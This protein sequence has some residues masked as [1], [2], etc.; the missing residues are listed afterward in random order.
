L[1]AE[2]PLAR[3][4]RSG[5]RPVAD[6]RHDRFAGGL[7]VTFHGARRTTHRR[8]HLP[9]VAAKIPDQPEHLLLFSG[10][11]L[12]G[13]VECLPAIQVV[14]PLTSGD[15]VGVLPLITAAQRIGIMMEGM[16]PGAGIPAGEVDE[17]VVH[18]R[19]GERQQ[20][21]RRR[22]PD[23]R[24]RL[25]QPHQDTLE[26]VAG[27]VPSPHLGKPQQHS[28]G[29]DTE[30]LDAHLQQLVSGPQ[31]SRGEPFEAD[32]DAGMQ[33]IRGNAIVRHRD[34]TFR[35]ATTRLFLVG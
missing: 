5:W 10:E 18:V 25:M 30:T 15:H 24:Q 20:I 11:L 16:R 34:F 9:L 21:A 23:R 32:A 27:V 31:I 12:D 29:D 6:G 2:M 4:N 14:I 35:S 22:R 17:F 8:G 28:A 13:H 3:A 26:D 7:P 1:N 19:C 33:G